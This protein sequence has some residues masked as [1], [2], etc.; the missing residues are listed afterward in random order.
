MGSGKADGRSG[1]VPLKLM[2]RLELL[3]THVLPSFLHRLVLAR[4]I[5]KVSEK[6][7]VEARAA[8]RIG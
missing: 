5:K 4:R 3:R 2:Q 7:D 1:Q 8:V 6:T